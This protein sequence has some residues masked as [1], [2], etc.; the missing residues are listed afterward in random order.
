LQIFL[1]CDICD[2]GCTSGGVYV[3]YIYTHAS[4]V[5]TG[6]SGLCC[7]TC[8]YFERKLTL[9]YVASVTSL[10]VWAAELAVMTLN[11]VKRVMVSTVES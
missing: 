10:S 2:R 5:T 7:C 4:R 3:P 6:D 11:F 9:L 8:M 1:G